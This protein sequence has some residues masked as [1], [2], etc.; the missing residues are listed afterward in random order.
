MGTSHRPLRLGSRGAHCLE[1]LESLSGR[2][3]GEL[4]DL[5]LRSEFSTAACNH[6]EKALAGRDMSSALAQPVCEALLTTPAATRLN[7][8]KR[9]A[10]VQPV[11]LSL[12]G[13]VNALRQRATQGLSGYAALD[14]ALTQKT[15][16]PKP[17]EYMVKSANP[18][19]ASQAV[20]ATDDISYPPAASV[21][22]T[23]Q[24]P[25]DSDGVYYNTPR[26]GWATN[27]AAPAPAAETVSTGTNA[28][29]TTR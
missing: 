8:G 25:P 21:D 7:P 9:H 19:D 24:L 3:A 27:A 5:C 29:N 28:T 6:A 16:L 20:I 11:R 4:K 14:K 15:G 22:Q 10:E 2:N 26:D 17:Y 1:L 18:T 13:S 12:L 23:I